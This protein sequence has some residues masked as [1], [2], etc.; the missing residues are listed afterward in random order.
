MTKTGVAKKLRVEAGRR[1]WR[2]DAAQA[3]AFGA[4]AA[5]V[6]AEGEDGIEARLLAIAATTR[7]QRVAARLLAFAAD[8]QARSAGNGE[9]P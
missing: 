8:A 6:E 1:L 2:G 5:A 4:A 3:R 9:K 7:H